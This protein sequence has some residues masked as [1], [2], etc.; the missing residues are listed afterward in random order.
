MN[1]TQKCYNFCHHIL[2]NDNNRPPIWPV[3]VTAIII[4][5]VIGE[6]GSQECTGG[7]C[8]HYKNIYQVKKNAPT[9]KKIDSLISRIKLNHTTIGWRRALL[10]AIVLSLI[11][12]VI[13]NPG[14]P[15]GFDFFLVSTILFLVI[16]FSTVWLQWHWHRCKD[17]ENEESLLKLR[18]Q[19][20][21][22]ELNKKHS[23]RKRKYYNNGQGYPSVMS[24]IESILSD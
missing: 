16:Y 3:I 8:N 22:M 21:D 14:L 17:Y 20:K 5:I 11:I 12:L 4:F 19:I 9:S 24:H 1:F 6:I 23:K 13:F 15:D 7:K 2:C 10:L 18:H